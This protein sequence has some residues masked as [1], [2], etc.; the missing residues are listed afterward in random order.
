MNTT[1]DRFEHLKQKF[2]P[3][4]DLLSRSSAHVLNLS[5]QDNKLLIRAAVADDAT[6]D[7]ISKEIERIDGSY[8]EVYP[9]IRVERGAQTPNTGQTKVQSDLEF[10]ENQ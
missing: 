4:L 1:Q 8:T 3:V 10:G 6:R 2:S 5:I 9:D 7:R